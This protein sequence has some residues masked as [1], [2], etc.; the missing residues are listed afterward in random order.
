MYINVEIYVYIQWLFPTKSEESI[1]QQSWNQVMEYYIHIVPCFVLYYM[2][3][4]LPQDA[5]EWNLFS[6]F[7]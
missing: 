2:H 4:G 1:N 6:R 7:K 5:V 3:F